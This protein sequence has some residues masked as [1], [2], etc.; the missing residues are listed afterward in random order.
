MNQFL[1]NSKTQIIKYCI[2]V[3]FVMIIGALLVLLQGGSPV[4]SFAAIING[5]LGSKSAIA[6]TIRWITPCIIMGMAASVAFKSG[7]NNLGLE[8]QMYMGAFVAAIV[9]SYVTLPHFAHIGV[10]I[11]TACIVAMLFALIPALL[12]LLL[13]IDEMI[14]TLMLNYVAVLLTEYLTRQIM[15]MDAAINPDEISTAPIKATAAL[16]KLIP[17]YSATTAIFIAVAIAI[18]IF[19]LNYYTIKGYELKQVGE[20]LP[21]AKQGGVRVWQTFLTIFLLSGLLAGVCGATEIIGPHGKFRPGFSS[22]LGWDG[23]MITLIAKNNPAGVVIVGILWGIL[24][25]GSFAMERVTNTNRL[26]V[27]LIQALFVLFV[28]IDY[29]ELLVKVKQKRENNRRYRESM[30]IGKRG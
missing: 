16:S 15:G 13:N 18:F 8:G 26:V 23:I 29:Q 19:V 12:R 22:N 10:V 21:F 27:T 25:N 7:V 20:N 2:V 1:Q 24:K 17:P 3:V 28:A 4:E 5:S 6:G 11:L 14:T 30:N 9:G